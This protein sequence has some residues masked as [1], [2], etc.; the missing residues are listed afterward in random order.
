[1]QDFIFQAILWD[2]EVGFLRFFF[3]I[4]SESKNDQGYNAWN[5]GNRD[6]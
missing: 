6:P 1:M 4:M 2:P 5:N 3:K